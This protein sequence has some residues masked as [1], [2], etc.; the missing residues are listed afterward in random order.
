MS[1]TAVVI[2]NYNGRTLLERYLPSLIEHTPGTTLVVADNA[3]TDDSIPFVR[4]H[5][6]TIQLLQLDKNYGYAGGYNRALGQVEADNWVLLNSDVEVTANWLEPMVH[7]LDTNPQIVS[8]QPKI[9]SAVDRERFDYAGAGGGL[10]DALGYPF[11]RGRIFNTLEIDRHQYDDIREVFWTSGACMLIRASAFRMDGGL[12]EGFFMHM[13]EIDWCW[14]IRRQGGRH[15]YCGAS[16]VFHLGGG[17]LS[18]LSPNKTYYNF[19]NGLSLVYRHWNRGE[20]LWKLPLRV[21]LDW[22]ASL[23][24]LLGGQFGHTLGVLRAHVRF[25]SG[26]RGEWKK[27]REV[28]VLGKGYGGQGIY[29]GSVVWAHFIGRRK[30]LDV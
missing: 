17:T 24:F 8:V 4:L 12:D 5:Y 20:L 27:R 10:M 25:L 19:R 28:Q 21:V 11:C 26:I 29:R 2:L 6:P 9:R 18:S 16:T 7:L 13:E 15:Y 1:R 22:I 30:K 3:S 23:R 14:R